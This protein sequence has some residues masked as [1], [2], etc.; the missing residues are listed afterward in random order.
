MNRTGNLRKSKT[1]VDNQFEAEESSPKAK[2]I[3]FGRSKT[4]KKGVLAKNFKTYNDLMCKEDKKGKKK[5][6]EIVHQNTSIILESVDTLEKPSPFYA[7]ISADTKVTYYNN[8]LDW[9]LWRRCRERKPRLLLN[10]H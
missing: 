5:Q 6:E 8:R 7:S 10:G 4:L 9:R 2:K 3:P 1:I